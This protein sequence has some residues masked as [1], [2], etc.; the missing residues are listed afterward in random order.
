MTNSIVPNILRFVLL[1]LLQAMIFIQ[2]AFGWSGRI[3]VHT[4]IY[5]LFI[6]LLPLNVPRWLMSV[7][8]FIMGILID[9]A[10]NSPG[11]HASAL[12]FTAFIRSS[13][14]ALLEPREGYSINM[15]PTAHKMGI[16]WFFRYAS[17]LLLIHLLFYFSVEVFT[18]FYFGEIILKT[19]FSYLS[20]IAFIMMTMVLFNPKS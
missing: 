16:S 13:V 20:S 9:I 7:L 2:F 5:P 8:A 10:Y 15:I 12:V 14:L 11:V 3:Y 4:I 17:I 1:I 19:I 6:M 18:F